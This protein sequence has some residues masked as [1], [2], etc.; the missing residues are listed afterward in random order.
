MGRVGY[1]FR[2]GLLEGAVEQKGLLLGSL[3]LSFDSPEERKEG[4]KGAHHSGIPFGDRKGGRRREAQKSEIF[5]LLTYYSAML[6]CTYIHL[7]TIEW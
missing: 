6:Y 1:F 2:K 4:W 5:S 7:F 3:L